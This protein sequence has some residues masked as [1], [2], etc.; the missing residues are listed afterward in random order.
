[1]ESKKSGEK[2]L[3]EESL[4]EFW[5]E[6]MLEYVSPWRSPSQVLSGKGRG[7]REKGPRR[8]LDSSFAELS[9]GKGDGLAMKMTCLVL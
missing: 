1:M 8:L 3:G 7:H 6:M 5:W 4:Q 2:R 9:G